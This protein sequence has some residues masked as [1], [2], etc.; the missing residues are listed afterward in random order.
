MDFSNGDQLRTR[1]GGLTRGTLKMC[2]IPAP[3]WV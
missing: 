1:D 3:E 2:E